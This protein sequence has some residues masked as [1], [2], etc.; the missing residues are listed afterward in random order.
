ML[1]S[2]DEMSPKEFVNGGLCRNTVTVLSPVGAVPDHGMP[3]CPCPH[4]GALL[5]AV[6]QR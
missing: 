6:S 1:L 2:E 5:T 3:A 4:L